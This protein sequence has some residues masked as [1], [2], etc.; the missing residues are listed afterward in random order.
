MLSKIFR[1]SG[2]ALSLLAATIISSTVV[3]AAPMENASA[4]NGNGE[5]ERGSANAFPY[6]R[7]DFQVKASC[8]TCL[9]RVAKA[10]KAT[11]GVVNADVSIYNPHWAV[12]II[13]TSATDADKVIAKVKK[14]KA[15]IDKLVKTDLKEKPLLVVPRSDTPVKQ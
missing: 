3:S 4:A 9:R 8:V 12:V 2:F 6:A 5:V 13:D 7:L 1:F 10:L 15:D 11:K 14:E